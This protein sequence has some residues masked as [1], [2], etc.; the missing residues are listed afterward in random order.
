MIQHYYPTAESYLSP[1]NVQNVVSQLFKGRLKMICSLWARCHLIPSVF[2]RFTHIIHILIYLRHFKPKNMAKIDLL[3]LLTLFLLIYEQKKR[4]IQIPSVKLLHFKC[5][6]NEKSHLNLAFFMFMFL[7]GIFMQMF[8]IRQMCHLHI[9]TLSTCGL[10]RKC[11]LE[12]RTEMTI[13]MST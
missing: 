9:C 12:L 8:L 10:L 2:W 4:D 13:N 3:W 7:F 5:Q 1:N 11:E 6:Q